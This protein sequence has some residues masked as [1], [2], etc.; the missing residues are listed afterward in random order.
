MIRQIVTVIVLMAAWNTVSAASQHDV[1]AEYDFL[2]EAIESEIDGI[3]FSDLSGLCDYA[4]RGESTIEP[5][6]LT[7]FVKRF[8]PSF[9]NEIAERYVEVGKI[10]GIRGDIAF[11][12]AILETGWFRFDRGTAVRQAQHNYCGLGVVREGLRGASFRTVRDGVTAHLQHL[13]AYVC[14]HPLPK[15]EHMVDPRFKA[16]RRG[17]AVN[18]SDLS[19][20]WAMN[21][22]YGSK[23]LK[24]YAELT[25]YKL[26]RL[27]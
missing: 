18:W 26:S 4:I 2:D 5:E 7:A 23:I 12:Q 24:I 13:Y 22:S 11:C 6:H 10:Y 19:N 25:E 20:R 15:G 1:I 8:N 21:D 9:D 14:S 16:V 27:Q 3:D 17:S